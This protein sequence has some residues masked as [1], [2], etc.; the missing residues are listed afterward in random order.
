MKDMLPVA[1]FVGVLLA[2]F[3]AVKLDPS[4]T[5]ALVGAGVVGLLAHGAWMVALLLAV[6]RAAV[7]AERLADVGESGGPGRPKM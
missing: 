3:A 4:R 5:E 2:L 1:A 6:R 7:A